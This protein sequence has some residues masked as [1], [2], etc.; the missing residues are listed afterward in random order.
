MYL[1]NLK[2]RLECKYRTRAIKCRGHYYFFRPILLKG[3]Y[4]SRAFYM[5]FLKK[6]TFYRLNVRLLF[7]SGTYSRAALNGARTVHRKCM[8]RAQVPCKK[9]IKIDFDHNLMMASFVGAILVA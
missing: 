9:G 4:Y 2:N 1:Y 7:E 6:W 5:K 3:G 8:R